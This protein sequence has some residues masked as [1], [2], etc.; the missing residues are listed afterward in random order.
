MHCVTTL[1]LTTLEYFGI[2]DIRRF[3]VLGYEHTRNIGTVGLDVTSVDRA[4]LAGL[5]GHT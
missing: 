5:N 4:M 3:E 2:T 1:A